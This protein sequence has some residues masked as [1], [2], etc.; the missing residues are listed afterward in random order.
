MG[1]MS[2][3]RPPSAPYVAAHDAPLIGECAATRGRSA[4][5]TDDERA[6]VQSA[7]ALD[8]ID[9][10]LAPNPVTRKQTLGGLV[11]HVWIDGKVMKGPGDL[12]GDGVAVIPVKILVTV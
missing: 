2:V 3:S 8:V 5:G 9:A 7:G 10:A 12:D 11:S 1:W 6:G 4:M